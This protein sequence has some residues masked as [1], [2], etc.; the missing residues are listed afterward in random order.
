[1]NPIATRSINWLKWL[2]RIIA[3]PYKPRPSPERKPMAILV[4]PGKRHFDQYRQ[5]LANLNHYE[6][7]V[8]T[9]IPD[10]QQAGPLLARIRADRLDTIVRIAPMLGLDVEQELRTYQV[11]ERPWATTTLH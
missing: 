5:L 10:P 3:P 4:K 9:Q 1:M 2:D 6:V 11:I 8:L 7:E